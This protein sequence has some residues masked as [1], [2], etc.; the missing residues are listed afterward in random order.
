[1]RKSDNTADKVSAITRRSVIVLMLISG[2]LLGTSS[3]WL[4][5]NGED[6][7]THTS[8]SSSSP[9]AMVYVYV[10][11]AVRR[12]GTLR[13]PA[14]SRA[15]DAIKACGGFAPRADVAK[16]NLAQPL[17]DGQQIDVP[18]KT[19]ADV[20]KASKESRAGD[21]VNLNTADAT[22]LTRLPGVGAVTAQRIISFRETHGAFKA[23]EDLKKVRGIGDKKFARLQDL[24]TVE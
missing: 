22:E 18:E 24:I 15:E 2:V 7:K 17:T 10:S 1:M 21:L 3:F 9:A 11:G 23:I 19:A 14:N 12:P 13:L 5:G 20:A 16:V 4:F 6:V 8:L